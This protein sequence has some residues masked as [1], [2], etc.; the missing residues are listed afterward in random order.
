MPSCWLGLSFWHSRKIMQLSNHN[1]IALIAFFFS[2]LTVTCVCPN[3]D[4]SNFTVEKPAEDDL[5]GTYLPLQSS[6]DFIEEGGYPDCQPRIIIKADGTFSMEQMP[7]WWNTPFGKSSGGFDAGE[8]TWETETC[9]NWWC[10][11]LHFDTQQN[12]NSTPSE[13]G[14][15]AT[16]IL[17]GTGQPYRLWFFVGDPDSGGVMIFKQDTTKTP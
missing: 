4:T 13:N 5:V 9:Q 7:D 16:I 17:A 1:R 6:L 14:R 12:F 8:G 11:V 3:M 2:I 15:I 10:L